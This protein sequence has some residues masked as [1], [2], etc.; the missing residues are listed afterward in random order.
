MLTPVARTH[1]GR[2][3]AVTC[4][5]FH[6]GRHALAEAGHEPL[7]E[8]D[9]FSGLG[10]DQRREY[11]SKHM[12]TAYLDTAERIPV[13]SINPREQAQQKGPER[14]GSGPLHWGVMSR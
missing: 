7:T 2:E 8:A 3:R 5:L 10:R 9:Y 14:G 4:G 11:L 1:L 13:V 12:V 6:L